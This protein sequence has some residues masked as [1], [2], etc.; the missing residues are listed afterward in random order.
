MTSRFTQLNDG[1][2]ADPNAP[3]EQ[4]D[5]HA[6][7]LALSFKLNRFQFAALKGE[8]ATLRFSGVSHYRLG[9]ENDHAWYEGHGRYPD[10]PRWGEFYE[11]REGIAE[12]DADGWIAVRRMPASRHFLFYLRDSTF[13]CLAD[14]WTLDRLP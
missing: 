3:N 8:R 14:D 6:F 7:E 2:N 1:W 13:E 12:I 4:V 11:V 5:L 9:E 10:V